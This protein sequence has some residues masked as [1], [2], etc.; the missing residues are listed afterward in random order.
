MSWSDTMAQL[1]E[2]PTPV[3][4]FRWNKVQEQKIPMLVWI[5]LESKDI[6]CSV[7]PSIFWQTRVLIQIFK[8][9]HQTTL[10]IMI[11][12]RYCYDLILYCFDLIWYILQLK[13]VH[14][15]NSR[16]WT[17]WRATRWWWPRPGSCLT[18][19]WGR[20][21]PT[22]SGSP[23]CTSWR[24]AH[25]YCKIAHI[26]WNSG[27]VFLFKDCLFPFGVAY[28]LQKDSP[29]TKRFRLHVFQLYGLLD[30]GSVPRSSSWRSPAWSAFGSDKSKTWWLRGLKEVL[31]IIC[32]RTQT[33]QI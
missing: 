29:Y 22:S 4:S 15:K 14:V 30:P 1:A 32:K 19:S 27:L 13:R 6:S 5:K 20:S 7:T 2:S 17:M 26:S 23:A 31:L 9:L 33:R 12:I 25:L 28:A 10:F 24:S 11:M 21:S 16:L 3:S 18:S 8:T